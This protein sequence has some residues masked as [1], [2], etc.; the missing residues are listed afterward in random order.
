MANPTGSRILNENILEI[1]YK[2]NARILDSRGELAEL[3]T[4]HM[5]LSEWL[6]GQ[7]RVDVFSKDQSTRF[8]V[9]FKNA[10][11]VMRNV[12]THE[13]FADQVGKFLRLVL[14]RQPFSSPLLVERL[15]V[16]SRFATSVS[17]PFGELVEAYAQRVLVPS[18]ETKAAFDAEM[19]DIGGPMNFLTP[20]GS[21]NSMSGPMEREQLARFFEHES[22][23]DLPDVAFYFELDYWTRPSKMMSTRDVLALS[24]RYIQEN[25][26]RHERMLVLAVGAK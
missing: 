18:S 3:L 12:S 8:F 24:K 11:A 25:W 16:K 5:A 26:E 13:Y 2:P 7:N 22:K 1:R 14:D 9:A 19:V 17:T 23:S 10:G 15:G 6:I 21:L 20:H 4:S